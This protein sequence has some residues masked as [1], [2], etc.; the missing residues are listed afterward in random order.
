MLGRIREYFFND[1]RHL[2]VKRMLTI[3]NVAE[4]VLFSDIYILKV[5]GFKKLLSD[6]AA[7]GYTSDSLSDINGDGYKDYMVSSYSGVGCCPRDARSLYLYNSHNGNFDAETLFNPDFD[8]KN[9]VIY[10]MEYGYP[11]ELSIDK[12]KWVG[13]KL[14]QAESIFPEH[15]AE[16]GNFPKPY[17][18]RKITYPGEKEELLTEVPQEYKN[19]NMFWYFTMY[20][21]K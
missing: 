11:G 7:Y 8:F 16:T 20:R 14:V 19:T 18:Y 9:R 3:G 12:Y 5:A 6:T 1:R 10:Q 17:R 15:A 4:P 2:I 13:N 21:D